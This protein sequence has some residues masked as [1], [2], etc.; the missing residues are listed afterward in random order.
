L[1]EMFVDLDLVVV[2]LDRWKRE[3]RWVCRG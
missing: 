2:W 3:I 1:L